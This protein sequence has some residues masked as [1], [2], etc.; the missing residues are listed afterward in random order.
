VG[1]GSLCPR[2]GYILNNFMTR[3]RLS[4][5]FEFP[6][7]PMFGI[8]RLLKIL[9]L[10]NSALNSRRRKWSRADSRTCRSSARQRYNL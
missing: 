1:A 10:V 6:D 3:T 2:S 8:A 4:D 5:A 9:S 7:L